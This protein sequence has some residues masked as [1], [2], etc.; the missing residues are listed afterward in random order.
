MM[1]LRTRKEKIVYLLL[2]MGSLVTV[3]NVASIKATG[4]S[5]SIFP[6]HSWGSY[7]S[8]GENKFSDMD[9]GVEEADHDPSAKYNEKE[10]TAD[11]MH[12]SSYMETADPTQPVDSV[13]SSQLTRNDLDNYELFGV[14]PQDMETETDSA[15]EVDTTMNSVSIPGDEGRNSSQYL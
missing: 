11:N 10:T 12:G 15:L 2:V 7:D 8:L 14:S 6:D 5:D 13:N 4:E 1:L 9:Y 3:R